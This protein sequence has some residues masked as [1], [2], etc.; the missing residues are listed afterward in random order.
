M[1]VSNRALYFD[2]CDLHQNV[3]FKKTGLCLIN[4]NQNLRINPSVFGTQSI[5]SFIYK[6]ILTIL[7][8]VMIVTCFNRHYVSRRVVSGGSPIETSQFMSQ[9]LDRDEM[10]LTA[11]LGAASDSKM[12]LFFYRRRTV[13]EMQTF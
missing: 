13:T 5:L 12:R 2:V 4:V 7:D 9:W 1:L 11:M 8:F 10:L 3:A 6:E